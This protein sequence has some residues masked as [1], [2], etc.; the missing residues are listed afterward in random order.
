M[1]IKFNP[2]GYLDL[3]SDPSDLPE[4]TDG[5]V[6][7]SDALTRCKNLELTYEGKAR[8]RW[9]TAKKSETAVTV[10]ISEIN[11]IGSYRYE[12]GEAIFYNEASIGTGYAVDM[13]DSVVGKAYNDTTQSIFALNGTNRVRLQGGAAYSWGIEAPD[14]APAVDDYVGTA[15]TQTWELDYYTAYKFTQDLTL[16]YECTYYWEVDQLNDD[17]LRSHTDTVSTAFSE[18]TGTTGSDTYYYKYT[19]ARKSGDLLLAESNPSPATATN[20]EDVV[21]VNWTEPTDPQVTHVLVY[22]TLANLEDYYYADEFEVGPLWGEVSTADEDLGSLIETDN[23]TPPLGTVIAGPDFNGTYFM[24]VDNLLYYSKPKEPESWP[25]LYNVEVG[26]EQYDIK[27]I[28]W[29]GG[30]IYVATDHEIYQI[31]G[32]D[33]DTFFPLPMAAITGTRASKVFLP[34]KGYGIIHLG[35]DGLYMYTGAQ[36]IKISKAI[37]NLWDGETKNG[38]PPIAKDYIANCLVQKQENKLWFGYP[39]GDSEHCNNF[40]VIDLEANLSQGLTS[41]VS[42]YSF[43]FE[44]TAMVYDEVNAELLAVDTDGYVRILE[45]SDSTSDSGTAIAWE[46]ESKAFGALR[47]YFPRWAR[48]DV[49]LTEETSTAQGKIL[50]DDA[51][52]QTHNITVSRNIK[53]RL[54]DGDNGDRLS[55]R[56][57]GTGPVEIYAAETE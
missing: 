1:S 31:T 14:V 2:T 43:P 5:K 36:D 47:K 26:N 23:D 17:T 42:Y 49:S 41:K 30:Q 20:Y 57:T 11:L 54:I 40:M 8:T 55:I 24:A 53:K 45:Y 34:I 4:K 19:Y 21:Y 18:V 3:T 7:V 22:R 44:I 6:T 33:A 35:W 29:L 56:L 48:Y 10:T 46:I 52:H 27:A 32:T 25:A 16:T 28:A 12:L 9:G 50:L 38:V 37:S 13:W 15:V 39:S 51:I